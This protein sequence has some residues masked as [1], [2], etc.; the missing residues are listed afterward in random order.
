MTHQDVWRGGN[1]G[2]QGGKYSR[3]SR[4]IIQANSECARATSAWDALGQQRRCQGMTAR[5]WRP[6]DA[7]AR[8]LAARPRGAD[9][10]RR[11]RLRPPLPFCDLGASTIS[12]SALLAWS[13]LSK[14]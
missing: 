13:R 4:V 5:D 10:P 7:V 1:I 11:W 3:R 8:M 2:D 12:S 6:G 14:R 9:E